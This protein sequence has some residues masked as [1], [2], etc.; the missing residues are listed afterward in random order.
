MCLLFNGVH[1]PEIAR[2]GSGNG[3]TSLKVDEQFNTMATTSGQEL[4]HEEAQIY[5]QST[6]CVFHVLEVI[7]IIINLNLGTILDDRDERRVLKSPVPAPRLPQHLQTFLLLA[8]MMINFVATLSW[9]LVP[10]FNVLSFRLAGE[11]QR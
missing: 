10:G 9:A 8:T 3:P 4:D 5:G 2:L 1:N 7:I 11:S 6:W